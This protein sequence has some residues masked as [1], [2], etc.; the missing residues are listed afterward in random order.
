M[1]SRTSLTSFEE[2]AGER[3]KHEFITQCFIMFYEIYVFT[4]KER[5]QIKQCCVVV[6]ADPSFDVERILRM[7]FGGIGIPVNDNYLYLHILTFTDS[8]CLPKILPSTNL[9]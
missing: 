5:N 9:D 3:E 6:I 4:F 8:L 7:V 1:T 2:T